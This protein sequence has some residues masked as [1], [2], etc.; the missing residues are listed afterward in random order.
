MNW[1]E[2]AKALAPE[3]ILL[4]GMVVVLTIEIFAPRPRGALA[5]AFLT[6]ALAMCAALWLYATGFAAEPFPE[7]SL[8]YGVEVVAVRHRT[9]SEPFRTAQ[10][11]LEVR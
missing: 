5:V 6:V 1:L 9:V 11:N 2:L 4:A 3:N 8:R 10:E 7:A